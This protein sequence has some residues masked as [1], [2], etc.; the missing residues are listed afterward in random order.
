[1]VPHSNLCRIFAHSLRELL[2]PYDR[3]ERFHCHSQHFAAAGND[4]LR[5]VCRECN[6]EC[7]D[8][9]YCNLPRSLVSH[10]GPDAAHYKGNDLW[11]IA[12]RSFD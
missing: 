7:L 9:A 11:P 4:L 6:C 3:V 12:S 2:S 10:C 5:A 8:G 1:M